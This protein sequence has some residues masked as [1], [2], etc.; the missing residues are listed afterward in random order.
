M[1]GVRDRITD[2][3]LQEN[4]ENS[5]GLLIDKTRDT[6]HTA[7]ASETANSRLCDTLDVVTK[8]LAVALGTAL[9]QTLR[10]RSSQYRV[11]NE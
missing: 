7:T 3:I 10:R 11:I 8:N 1:F 6:F 2:N 4:L 9:A 5:A